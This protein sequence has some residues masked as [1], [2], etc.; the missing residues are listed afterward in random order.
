MRIAANSPET[1]PFAARR[2]LPIFAAPLINPPERLKGGLKAYHE[3]LP[4]GAKGDTALA[5]SGVASGNSSHNPSILWTKWSNV[6]VC[7]R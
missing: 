2:G 3:A 6:T 5:F 7:F 4:G 1:F